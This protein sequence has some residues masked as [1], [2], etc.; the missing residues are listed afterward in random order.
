M[1]AIAPKLMPNHLANNKTAPSITK[2]APRM[3]ADLKIDSPAA[4]ETARSWIDNCLDSHEGCP[5]RVSTTLPT[6]VLDIRRSITEGKVYLLTTQGDHG[7]YAAL[8][9]CWGKTHQVLTTQRN[10]STFVQQGITVTTLPKTI[11]NAISSA[12]RLSIPY[13]W[14]DS[15]CILQD[16]DADKAREI[17]KMPLIYKNAIVTISAASAPD[18]GQGFLEERL[19]IRKKFEASLRLP[20]LKDTDPDI[21]TR[22][23]DG[24]LFLCVDVNLGHKITALSDEPVNK[25]GWTLQEAWLSPRMLIYGSGALHWRCLSRVITRGLEDAPEDRYAEA[26]LRDR[27]RFYLSKDSKREHITSATTNR[28]EAHSEEILRKWDEILVN[29]SLRSLS[30]PTDKLPALS[31]LATEFHHLLPE[32]TYLAGL[33]RSTL[34]YSL[35]WHHQNTAVS[36][37][38]SINAEPHKRE[39]P[40]T[41]KILNRIARILRKTESQ[42]V[43]ASLEKEDKASSSQAYTVP[44]WSPMHN[45]SSLRM[46]DVL[47]GTEGST[48]VTI[49][50]ATIT[51]ANS[52]A[53]FS[54]ITAGSIDLT[55]PMCR[56]SWRELTGRFVL[57]TEGNPHAYWDYIIPDGGVNNDYFATAARTEHATFN[58]QTRLEKKSTGML[59]FDAPG[60]NSLGE[61]RARPRPPDA[62][63]STINCEQ[64]EDDIT[65]GSS[66]GDDTTHVSENGGQGR[67]F[68]FLEI[69][70]TSQ[71]AGLVLQLISEG[72]FV[73]VGFFSMGLESR[74]GYQLQDPTPDLGPR[75]WDWDSLLEMR[76]IMLV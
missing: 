52:F 42:T 47:K 70:H 51:P 29:Y 54:A 36:P 55:A 38:E 68:W 31:G 59:S 24:D 8:S 49:H 17:S 5:E 72:V 56:M 25:R 22:Q 30:L 34:P 35:L 69:I 19:E 39:K 12:H 11:S 65:A 48:L 67:A 73:R 37:S 13:L 6:R 14:I 43:D 75:Q 45:P 66:V 18:C 15:L 4:Y 40:T 21:S 26:H 7:E 41:K 46:S 50:D 53:P 76:R 3:S 33:W 32:D 60:G 1:Y 10:I 9:Y 71:P 27:S 44:S 62:S 57:V 28:T 2:Y 20:V 16:S 64:L 74:R 61:Q 63:T 58:P 23:S